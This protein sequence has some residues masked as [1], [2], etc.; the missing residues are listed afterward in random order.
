MNK[1]ISN[2]NQLRNNKKNK[3]VLC[4]GH[5]NIIHPGHIQYLEFAKK[6]GSK[7]V[8]A[9]QNKRST[10]IKN[11]KNYFSLNFFSKLFVYTY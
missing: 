1:I 11:T 3:I 7:L 10:G 6:F 8:V 4:Y 5:F 9:I 2:L